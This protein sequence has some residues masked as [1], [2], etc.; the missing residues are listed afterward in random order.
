M[1]RI[2]AEEFLGMI[3]E[4]PS[5]FEHWDTPLEITEYVDCSHTNIT[6]LSPHLT[7]S[8]N[9]NSF[10]KLMAGTSKNLQ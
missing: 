1:K 2:T 10:E 8:G 5:V 4:N 3:A 7:F 9:K 6:H